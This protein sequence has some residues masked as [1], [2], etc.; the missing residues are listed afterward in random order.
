MEKRNKDKI[1]VSAVSYLN[2]LPL[3]YGLQH[4]KIVQKISLSMDNPSVCAQKLIDGEADLGLVPIASIPK[5]SN[6]NIISNYCIG[7]DGEVKTVLLLSNHP[8]DEVKTIYLDTES[9]TSVKLVKVL[10]KK[11]WNL[12]FEWKPTS[13]LLTNSAEAP[14]FVLIGNKTFTEKAKY[15]YSIDL[16]EE[17]KKFTGLPFVFACWVA[18]KPLPLQ[19]INEFDEAMEL[20]L[21]NI[22]ASVTQS[23]NGLISKQELKDYLHHSISYDFDNAKKEAMQLFL[24]SI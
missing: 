19:F 9:R 17:W 14:A 16:A 15:K 7:A 20:G 6:A 8:L 12:S 23:N 18:N 11:F 3:I 4:S 2:T 1:R 13:E 10:A 5:I 21:R 22:N 24:D